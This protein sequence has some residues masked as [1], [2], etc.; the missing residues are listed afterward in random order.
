MRNQ[1][2]VV[3]LSNWRME[4]LKL[5]EGGRSVTFVQDSS[6]S[7][8][9]SGTEPGTEHGTEPGTKPGT[10]PGAPVQRPVQSPEH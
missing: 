8:I 9:L 1:N 2:F 7:G 5:V 3:E 6:Q 10:K 4:L